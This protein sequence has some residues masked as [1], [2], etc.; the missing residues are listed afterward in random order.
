MKRNHLIY[1]LLLGTVISIL[2]ACSGKG[3][4]L[5]QDMY[6]TNGRDLYIQ[7]CQ[8]CHGD[9]GEGL[10][11]LIPPLTDTSYLKE[12]RKKLVCFIK[13]GMD[14]KI[15]VDGREFVEKMPS[16]EEFT[17]IDLAQLVVFITNS[18]GNK[19]GMYSTSDVVTDLGRCKN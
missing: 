11:N 16:H 1:T 4:S 3:S 19:Q 10:E 5:E 2:Y 17:D 15:L 7:H 9:K 6:Y 14:G 12:N 18:N 8:N 13:Y